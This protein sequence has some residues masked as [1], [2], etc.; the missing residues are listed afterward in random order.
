[1]DRI[2]PSERIKE[3]IEAILIDGISDADQRPTLAARS[4]LYP[5]TEAVEQAASRYHALLRSRLYG[6]SL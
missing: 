3:Q 5:L 2:A 4:L 6:P 1:M